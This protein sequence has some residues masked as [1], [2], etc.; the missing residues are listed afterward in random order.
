MRRCGWLPVLVLVGTWLAAV[1]ALAAPSEADRAAARAL[2]A[3]GFHALQ[4]QDFETAVDRF[5][6]ADAL[7]HAP[8]ILVDL[9]R[10][11][12]GLGRFVEAHEQ[13]MIVIREGV[14]SKAPRSWHKAL[15]AAREE[16]PQLEARLAWLTIRVS[17][18]AEPNVTV[19]GEVWPPEALDVRR[20][21]DPGWHAIRISAPGYLSVER[22][23]HLGE[24]EE[25]ALDIY[26]EREP[27]PA[28]TTTSEPPPALE[29]GR[30][31]D[32]QRILAY[33]A[34]GVGGA[35]LIVGSV[36]GV[37]A[38]NQRADLLRACGPERRCPPE[39][40]SAVN[41][42]QRFGI[43]SGVGFAMAVAG[44]ATG[45]VL[46]LAEPAA[47]ANDKDKGLRVRPYVALGTLGAE[48]HF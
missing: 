46:W 30:G 1:P 48:G 10:A 25:G 2:A 29:P 9:A 33:V 26:M 5:R 45:T 18:A 44:A 22:Q 35:G 47:S 32:T 17:V 20:P 43:L 41:A 39:H 31:P 28:L 34:Y 14:E 21:A 4:R 23:V 40:E 12:V 38:L 19:N 3:E 42:Y 15:A 8:T 27:L 36:F 7:V 16:A 11:L 37:L 24:G 6:R 13:Y